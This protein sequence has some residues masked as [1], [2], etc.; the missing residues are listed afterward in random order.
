M[1]KFTLKS[2]IICEDARKEDNGKEMLIGV[3]NDVVV[4]GSFPAIIDRLFVRLSI[5]CDPDYEGDYSFSLT[6]PRKQEILKIAEK[7]G[8]QPDDE[9]GRV[10]GFGMRGFP[11]Q[12]EGYYDIH[13]A[14][15]KVPKKIGSFVVRMPKIESEVAR[16][17]LAN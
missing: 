13:F 9:P 16:L 12:D 17:A 8:K 6:G 7:V 3:Y 10:F 4:V 2:V 1:A 15:G 5:D 11:A 14:L